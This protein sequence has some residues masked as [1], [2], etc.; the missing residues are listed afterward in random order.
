MYGWAGKILRVD[1]TSREV[2]KEPL[3]S[4]L[5]KNYIG[6]RGINSRLLYDE[7]EPGTD[8]FDPENRLIFGYGC[9]DARTCR[10]SLV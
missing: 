8:S 6:G 2:K 9:S 4:N 1:L 5:R 3:E 7:V 10:M